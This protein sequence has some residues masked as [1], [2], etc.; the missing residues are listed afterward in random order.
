MARI[1]SSV[2]MP[3]GKIER[4]NRGFR[5]QNIGL[6]RV[7]LMKRAMTTD[8]VPRS[9]F[10]NRYAQQDSRRSQLQFDL[11]KVSRLTKQRS[12]SRAKTQFGSNSELNFMPTF[13]GAKAKGIVRGQS[14][15]ARNT[16]QSPIGLRQQKDADL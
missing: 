7:P 10:P 15:V 4:T 3:D 12:E 6:M 14:M 5:R 2:G 16:T 8:R 13:E 11:G 9:H 1:K